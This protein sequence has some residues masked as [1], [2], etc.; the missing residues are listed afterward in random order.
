MKISVRQIC[1]ILFAYTAATRLLLYPSEL[2]NIS[3]RN[4]IFSAMIDFII[5]GVVIWAVAYLCSRTDKSFYTL[6]ADTFGDIFA[7]VVYGLFALYFMLVTLVPVFEQKLYVHAIFYDTVPS[8][9]VFLPFFFFAVYAGSKGFTNI[10]RSADLCMPIFLGCIAFIFAMSIGEAKFSNLLPL[11][12]TPAKEILGGSIATAFRFV[13]PCWLLMFAGSFKYK[14]GDAAKITLSYAG[15]ALIVLLFLA[16]FYG[17]YGDITASRSF[18]ISKTSLYF[19]ALDTLGR[20]DLIVLYILEIVMLFALVLNIQLAVHCFSQC[21]G[22]KDKF[23][24]SMIVNAVFAVLLVVFNHN[25]HAISLVYSGWLWIATVIF[26]I[27]IPLLSWALK[28]SE[29]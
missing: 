25:Y 28:R 26:T 29:K 5:Q 10:G 18:A 8:L 20:I 23:V 21:T 27:L 17:V 3:G 1:F 19:P 2:V 14:K 9:L 16:V 24:I 13:E 11:L 15:G 4:Y 12:Q 7:R 6:L 22:Y